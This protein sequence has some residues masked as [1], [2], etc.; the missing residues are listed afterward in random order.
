[1]VQGRVTMVKPKEFPPETEKGRVI[2]VTFGFTSGGT[3]LPTFPGPLV[4]RHDRLL[5]RALRAAL[6]PGKSA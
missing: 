5:P 3:T 1:V 2:G 4:L 6:R